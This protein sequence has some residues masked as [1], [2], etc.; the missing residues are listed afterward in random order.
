[1]QFMMI[2]Q[3]AFVLEANATGMN[4]ARNQQNSFLIQKDKEEFKTR[5]KSHC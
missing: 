1:M 2:L 5:K 4:I 3:K